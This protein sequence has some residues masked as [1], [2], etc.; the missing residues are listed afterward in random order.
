MNQIRLA[1]ALLFQFCK[2]TER[3]YGKQIITPNMH[4]HYHLK[5]C[6][7]DHL[8]VTMVCLAFFPTTIALLSYN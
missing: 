5:D 4:M 8:N 6:I 2:R 3:M 7:L 1:D